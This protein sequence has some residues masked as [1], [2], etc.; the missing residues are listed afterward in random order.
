M[1]AIICALFT[2]I[3]V[4]LGSVS[5]VFCLTSNKQVVQVAARRIIAGMKYILTLL[6]IPLKTCVRKNMGPD[7]SPPVKYLSIL[8]PISH[9]SQPFPAFGWITLSDFAEKS[10]ENK[11]ICLA[12]DSILNWFA[13]H[14]I[15]YSH[16]G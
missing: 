15:K 1:S 9:G 8:S 13:V 14:G 5:I 7:V 4:L 3:P 16:T 2:G 6:Y 12:K 10:K 11:M